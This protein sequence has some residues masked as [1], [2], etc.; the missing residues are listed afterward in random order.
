M[1]LPTTHKWPWAWEMIQAFNNLTQ[2][3]NQ[4]FTRVTTNNDNIITNAIED[5][6]INH[7]KAT[8]H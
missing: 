3:I 4:T 1:K 8:K 7:E 5:E 6:S 2:A